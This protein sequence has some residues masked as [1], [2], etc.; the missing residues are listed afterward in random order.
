MLVTLMTDASHCSTTKVAGF[1]FWCV[2]N[3]GKLSGGKPLNG[4]VE[5]A[6]QAEAKAVANSLIIGFRSG[7]IQQGDKVIIQL[8][9]L[10]VVNGLMGNSKKVRKDVMDVFRFIK[11]FKIENNIEIE[12]RHVKG[13]TKRK[14][15]RF[16]ANHHCDKIAKEQMKS[17]RV[18][19]S[20]I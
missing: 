19:L 9:N 1:G 20:N 14:E 12:C 18:A 8:D 2:S 13:H 11:N 15:S 3:R 10:A 17:A 4:K 6:Y 16:K 5:D 7:I